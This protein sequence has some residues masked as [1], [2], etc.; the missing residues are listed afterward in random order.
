MSGWAAL[1]RAV[2]VGGTN[3][4]PMAE[5]KALCE[6]VGLERVQTYI[7]SGNGCSNPAAAKPLCARQSRPH[8]LPLTANRSV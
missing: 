3:K 2:N 8:C 4:L 5:L 1:L 7:A 6:G